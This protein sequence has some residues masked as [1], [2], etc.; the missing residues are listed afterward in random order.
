MYVSFDKIKSI[1]VSMIGW[2]ISDGEDVETTRTIFIDT[3]DGDTHIIS[4][5]ANSNVPHK[6]IIPFGKAKHT[7]TDEDRE[8]L[9]LKDYVW[10]N[11]E[12]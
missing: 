6:D 3:E 4:L 8:A 7:M 11:E 5:C 9:T 1:R 2:M 12:G 10:P